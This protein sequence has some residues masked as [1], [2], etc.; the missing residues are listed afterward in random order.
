MD[1]FHSFVIVHK[2][3]NLKVCYNLPTKSS[4]GEEGEFIDYHFGFLYTHWPIQD[5]TF[6]S[7][8]TCYM[9]L[10]MYPFHPGFQIHWH[11]IH[12]SSFKRISFYIL[13]L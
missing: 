9:F 3:R 10:G 6:V 5:L 13:F 11:I 4:S 12:H 2:I 8:L 1:K 7:I